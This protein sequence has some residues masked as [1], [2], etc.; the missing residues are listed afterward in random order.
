MV[1]KHLFIA[2]LLGIILSSNT[3]KKESPSLA[4]MTVELAET[5]LG[6]DTPAPRFGWQLTAVSQERGI[7]Q[8][9]YQLI[10]QDEAG[11]RVWDSGK[12]AGDVSQH[13]VYQGE[14]LQPTT[15]YTWQVKVWNNQGKGAG[16][17]VLV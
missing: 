8:T 2:I 9:A 17:N 15:R 3:Y 10:V 7:Y 11:K 1:G 5:P 14:A 12:V 6:V 13:V 4:G 16:R